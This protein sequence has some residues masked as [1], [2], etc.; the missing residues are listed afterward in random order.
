VHECVSSGDV[1]MCQKRGVQYRYKILLLPTSKLTA[2]GRI[3]ENSIQV[4]CPICQEIHTHGIADNNPP[5]GIRVAH[6]LAGSY[7]IIVGGGK[8]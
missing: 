3:I 5:G 6:C 4:K 8:K 1:R 7:N 2:R